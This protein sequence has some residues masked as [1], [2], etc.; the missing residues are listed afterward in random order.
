M[1]ENDLITFNAKI[2]K[3]VKEDFKMIVKKQGKKIS[4][5]LNEILKRYVNEYNKNNEIGVSNG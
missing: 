4:F 1:N 3:S 5:E 2:E